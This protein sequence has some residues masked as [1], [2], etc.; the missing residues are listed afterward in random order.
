MNCLSGKNQQIYEILRVHRVSEGSLLS[1]LGNLDTPV[2]GSRTE[3]A[4][5]VCFSQF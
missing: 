5:P 3:F 4:S 1:G 2:A